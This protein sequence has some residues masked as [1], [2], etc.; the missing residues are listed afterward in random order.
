MARPRKIGLDYF[1]IKVNFAF[2]DGVKFTMDDHGE[3][4]VAG[5][6]LFLL[7]EIYGGHGYY[8]RWNERVLRSFAKKIY[9]DPSVV[10]AVVESL[11]NNGA[12]DADLYAR[13]G[14]LT[15]VEMQANY[16]RACDKREEIVILSDY[17]L[18]D[19]KDTTRA[20][21]VWESLPAS[22]SPRNSSG[23][24]PEY[25]RNDTDIPLESPRISS[26]F[27]PETCVFG[28]GIPPETS[29]KSFPATETCVFGPG[30]PQTKLNNTITNNNN[31]T[32]VSP[33][34]NSNLTT[35]LRMLLGT[36][37]AQHWLT[38]PQY[39]PDYCVAQMAHMDRQA[40]IRNPRTWLLAALNSNY[41]EWKPPSPKPDPHCPHCNGTGRY[42]DWSVYPP[43]SHPCTCVPQPASVQQP[44]A[45]QAADPTHRDTAAV[46]ARLSAALTP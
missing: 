23:I 11:I 45:P 12:F 46:T 43:M 7:A 26:G 24:P 28:P 44:P 14:I 15:S 3:V 2:Q 10:N 1:P 4:Q 31:R 27:P 21:I 39:G 5:I 38:D 30:N 29:E 32:T 41:A 20:N 40:G 25:P 18:L 19:S 16:V 17:S 6:Y 33:V 9:S 42:T 34:D 36:D 37:V 35:R 13:H 22:D 8:M